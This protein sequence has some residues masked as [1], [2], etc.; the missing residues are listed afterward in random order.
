MSNVGSVVEGI[1]DLE[2]LEEALDGWLDDHFS[3]VLDIEV[4]NGEVDAEGHETKPGTNDLRCAP[5]MVRL[6]TDNVWSTQNETHYAPPSFNEPIPK[7]EGFL[8]SLNSTGGHGSEVV[9]PL[10][11]GQMWASGPKA[12]TTSI[13]APV[14]AKLENP[15]LLN[16]WIF[17]GGWNPY[18]GAPGMLPISWLLVKTQYTAGLQLPLP[19]EARNLV[20]DAVDNQEGSVAL[21]EKTIN[22]NVPAVSIPRIGINSW[23]L[24]EDFKPISLFFSGYKVKGVDY[25]LD[26]D[27]NPF[28]PFIQASLFRPEH[29]K[30]VGKIGVIVSIQ[31]P[32]SVP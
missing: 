16:L 15:V 8:A 11:L 24:M 26:N 28:L 29:D 17:I 6:N 31:T 12:T 32:E 18:H 7:L 5:D 9:L 27:G 1:N 10:V 13:P 3:Y 4:S 20:F 30:T 23:S 19:T 25:F 21:S 14:A 2:Q 22:F